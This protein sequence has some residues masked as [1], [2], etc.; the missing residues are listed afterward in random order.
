MNQALGNGLGDRGAEPEGGHKIKESSPNDGAERRE[1]ASGYDSGDGIGGVV[2]AIGKFKNKRNGDD[3]EEQSEAVHRSGAL[4]DDAFDD[5]GDVFALVDGGFDDFEDFFPLND[6]DGIFLFVEELGDKRAA[7]AVAF[8]FVAIDLDAVL[9]GFLRGFECA[10]GSLYLGRGRDENLDEVNGA[11]PNSVHAVEHETAGGRVD[12]VDDVV[13]ADAEVVNCFAVK[14]REKGLIE[15]GEEGVG[16]LVAFVLDG[17]D[18]LHLF[19]HAGVVRE[20]FQQGFGAHMDI[21]CLFGEEVEETLFA[22]QEPL[23][24]SW[25]DV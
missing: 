8:V 25:H 12:Q 15:L 2:P 4:E 11:G 18:D 16:K 1:D 24:E 10:D 23:Q 20:H 7:K 21:R 17:F 22:R 5:V 3:D 14:G 6:L 13:E 9:E 19:R